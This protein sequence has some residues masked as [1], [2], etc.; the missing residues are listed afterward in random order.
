MEATAAGSPDIGGRLR[1]AHLLVAGDVDGIGLHVLDLACAQLGHGSV[2]PIL[3]TSPSPGYRP[4]LKEFVGPLV[5]S[6]AVRLAPAALFYGKLDLRAMG[7]DLVHLHGYRA[8]HLVPVLKRRWGLPLIATCH[9]LAKGSRRREARAGME[10]RSYRSLEMVIAT[11]SEQRSRITSAIP[12]LPVH[13]IPNGVTVPPPGRSPEAERSLRTRFGFPP[14]S[15]VVAAVGRLH[16]QKRP[17]LFLQACRWISAELPGT[18]FLVVGDGPER[19]CLE[20]LARAV[21]LA[22]VIHFAG[23]V[24]DVPE[25]CRGISLLLHCADNEG[26]PR[27]VLHA[28]AAGC[29][30]V[31]TS[32]AGAAE[33]ITDRSDGVLVPCGDASG[34]AKQAVRL[35][36][37][38]ESRRE[39]GQRARL[40]VESGF[41][42]DLMR[43][44]VEDAYRSVMSTS[45]IPIEESL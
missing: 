35:L 31:A 2:E 22:P 16:P 41:S 13:Y 19:K 39:L 25:L 34:I 17:D 33:L 4:W 36:Q 45:Q 30:V 37:R 32:S 10:I 20:K 24:D 42:I 23:M 18:R 5:C 12:G 14:G 11:N 9:L 15:D 43:R 26:T 27:A 3:L 29:A 1:V 6:R 40:K 8:G 38:P 21:G 28:M 7:V 44:R